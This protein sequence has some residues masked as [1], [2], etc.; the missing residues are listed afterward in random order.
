MANDT[1]DQIKQYSQE[2]KQHHQ[3]ATYR[4]WAYYHE[5]KVT[6]FENAPHDQQFKQ[7]AA[8]IDL[9]LTK[10]GNPGNEWEDRDVSSDWISRRDWSRH[11]TADLLYGVAL[12]LIVS[13]IHLKLD[14]RD[15]VTHMA[16]TEGGTPYIDDS[17]C[18]LIQDLDGDIP[19]THVEEIEETLDLAKV[20]R[21]N[22]VHFGY[23][24]HGGPNYS[25]LFVRVAGYLID[26]YADVNDIP[27]L[28]K[29]AGFLDQLD[30]E[31]TSAEIYPE[32]GVDFRPV[33]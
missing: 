31:R 19:E 29:M 7:A 20:K 16:R 26:R 27:E 11:M 2:V 22:L 33:P 4:I 28:K 10:V 17:R 9:A 15:Y 32:L 3:S 24:Y 8:Y 12:E 1:L 23:H 13:A 21:N 5:P 18:Y 14:T 30:N 6:K 25:M